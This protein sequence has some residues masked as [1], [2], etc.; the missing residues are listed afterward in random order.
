MEDIQV[1]V[2]SLLKKFEE[3]DK[4]LK[5]E[6]IDPLR[7]SD[8]VVEYNEVAELLIAIKAITGSGIPA[9]DDLV[10]SN[11]KARQLYE[12]YLNYANDLGQTNPP[13]TLDLRMDWASRRRNN[14]RR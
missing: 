10:S 14:P 8:L 6:Y 7:F 3:L 12:E 2:L 9:L 1:D 11:E 4:I 5:S 13:E